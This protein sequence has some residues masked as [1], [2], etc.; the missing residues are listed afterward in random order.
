MV[1]TAWKVSV[2]G[3]FLVRFQSECGKMQIRKTLNTGTFQAVLLRQTILF[4]GCLPQILFGPFLNTLLHL[5]VIIKD[6]LFLLIWFW[7]SKAG[8]FWMISHENVFV[9]RIIVQLVINPLTRKLVLAKIRK[10]FFWNNS[11]K[12]CLNINIHYSCF[13]HLCQSLICFGIIIRSQCVAPPLLTP[14]PLFFSVEFL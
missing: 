13:I 7:R 8:W 5:S 4:V 3:V 1:F 14:F 11:D 9:F 10:S 2:F 12:N 6:H